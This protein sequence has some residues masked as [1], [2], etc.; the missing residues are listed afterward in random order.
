MSSAIDS[1]PIE[2]IELIELHDARLP[3]LRWTWDAT[4]VIDVTEAYLYVAAAKTDA[5]EAPCYDIYNADLELVCEGLRSIAAEGGA[6]SRHDSIYAATIQSADQQI[7]LVA[8]LSGTHA[9][10][11]DFEFFPAGTLAVRCSAVR[12][13]IVSG[14]ERIGHWPGKLDDPHVR[15]QWLDRRGSR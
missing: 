2:L 9:D 3:S 6:F 7:E 13:R 4:A 8:V 15:P 14:L 12:A 1:H 10:A 5:R 11:I